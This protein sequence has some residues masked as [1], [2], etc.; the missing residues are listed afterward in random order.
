M[1]DS[2]TSL[3]L[4]YHKFEYRRTP[5]RSFFSVFPFRPH[6]LS[7][8]QKS[9]SDI[10]TY[11]H[12]KHT[13]KTKLPI[14]FIHGIGIGLWPYVDFLAEING[15]ADVDETVGIIAIEIMPV[16]FRITA[17]ALQKS[18]MCKEIDKILEA[19]GWDKLV[20]VSHSYVRADIHF[21][22]C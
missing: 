16:S 3:Q 5:L 4:A 6:N 7:A 2:L 22:S 18:K 9:P 19:H 21:S 15:K 13:S 14:L 11:W 12:R 10:L 17:Q 8:K 1:V 20:L